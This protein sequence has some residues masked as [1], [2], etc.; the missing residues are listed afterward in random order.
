[1]EIDL[2]KYIRKRLPEELDDN[3]NNNFIETKCIKEYYDSCRIFITGSTGFLGKVLV[4]KLLR[5]C[6]GIKEIYILLRPKR[7][8]AS[9]K[10]FQ[11]FLQ[12][13]IFE[14]I[15]SKNPSALKKLF[16]IP[17]DINEPNVGLDEIG[18]KT[19]ENIDI[20]FHIA[21]TVRF[22]EPLC[23]ASNLNTFGTQRIM[24]LCCKMKK[25]KVRI[26]IKI[27][28]TIEEYF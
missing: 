22:N 9:E 14:R 2:S 1:M 28:E 23:T 12:N 16:C 24:E 4:E 17:G 10:R 18:M 11:D 27:N 5:S 19:L 25:L 15:Q 13:P 3:N 26:S 8:V 6:E 7:G 20:V 21:A